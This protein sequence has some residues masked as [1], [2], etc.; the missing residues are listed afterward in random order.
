MEINYNAGWQNVNTGSKIFEV[1]AKVAGGMGF[2][3]DLVANNMQFSGSSTIPLLGPED[4]YHTVHIPTGTPIEIT[5]GAKIL[6]VN[7][8]V[9][10]SF[11]ST[12]GFEVSGKCV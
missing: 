1:E 9:S 2:N 10:G 6:A 5:L 3:I 11:S 7:A 8:I 12:G 4:A